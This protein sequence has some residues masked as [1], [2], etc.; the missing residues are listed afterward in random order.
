[1]KLAL[2]KGVIFTPSQ[3]IVGILPQILNA[4]RFFT[5]VGT[6]VVTSANDGTHMQGSKHFTDDA[7]DLRVWR[8][9]RLDQTNVVAFLQITLGRDYDVVDERNH[10]HVEYD[11]K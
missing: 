6:V 2:K 9:S 10:I 1:M 3:E 4:Y 5:D 11:R 7:L 8:L